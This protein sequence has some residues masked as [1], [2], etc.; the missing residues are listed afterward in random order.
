[1]KVSAADAAK[2]PPGR[3]VNVA[4]LLGG[5]TEESAQTSRPHGPIR[6]VAAVPVP[7]STNALWRAIRTAR[8]R[9]K[10]VRSRGYARWRESAVALMRL[11]L[12]VPVPPVGVRITVRGGKG[13]V[14]RRD[15]DNVIKAVIDALKDAGRIA[16]DSTAVVTAVT[17]V[18]APP[19]VGLGAGCEVCFFDPARP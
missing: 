12:P 17:A 1:M 10:V 3:G 18:F 13:W 15:L 7:P 8:G 5:A 11:A 14:A 2:M 6:S 4:A 16:D 19:V 9:V